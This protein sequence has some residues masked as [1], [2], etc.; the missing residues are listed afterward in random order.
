MALAAGFTALYL[1]G[2]SRPYT[3]DG[4]T[5]IA[6]NIAERPWRDALGGQVIYSNHP[7]SS[8]LGQLV[9]RLGGTTESWQR[10]IPAVAAGLLV[11]IVHWATSKRWSSAA[12][13]A[14]AVILALN[15]LFIYAARTV[16]GYALM[17]LAVVV[18]TLILDRIVEA[19]RSKL[20]VSNRL[21]VAY[22]LT[23]G[24]AI[25]A[26]AYGG[27]IL[28]AHVGYVVAHKLPLRPWVAR[29]GFGLA[30]GG[31]AYSLL[32]GSLF[33]GVAGTSSQNSP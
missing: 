22:S 13:L 23:I 11:G 5:S 8:V 1:V 28:L 29:F 31:A 30:V 14:A 10:L 26:H 18:S 9:W 15:P 12:G 7:L 3:H 32:L 33:A 20:E 6:F 25:G 21:L 19:E 4:A 2:S 17:M 16:R 27:M 24:V